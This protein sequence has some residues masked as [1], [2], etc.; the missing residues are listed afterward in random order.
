MFVSDTSDPLDL[1]RE[2][3]DRLA[4]EDRSAWSPSARSARLLELREVQERAEAE[5]IRSAA[6]WVALDD[7]SDD[8]RLG[9]TSWLAA[10]SG[11][12]GSEA[13]RLVRAA[14]LV[15]GHERTGRALATGQ[16]SPAQVHLLASA[17]HDRS[18]QYREFEPALLDAARK[19][20]LRDFVK[21]TRRWR[22]LAD[23][24][25]SRRDAAFAF[26]RRGLTLSPTIGGSVV[27]GFLDP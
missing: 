24:E 16:I 14:R 20:E 11:M 26:E 4:A 3:L 19:V 7:S 15:H 6:G 1:V 10:R 13:A 9:P 8:S 12:T 21:V 17:G 2:G 22:E 27:S 5:V 25:E 18:A 23:D